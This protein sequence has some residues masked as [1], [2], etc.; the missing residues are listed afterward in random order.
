MHKKLLTYTI[1]PRSVSG[2]LA[3]M[4]DTVMSES[5]KHAVFN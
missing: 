3:Q 2:A 4:I 5:T 1:F